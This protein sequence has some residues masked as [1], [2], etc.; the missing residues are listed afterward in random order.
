MGLPTDPT[1]NPLTPLLNLVNILAFLVLLTILVV[2]LF[3]LFAFAGFRSS[4]KRLSSSPRATA[5][6]DKI[7]STLTEQAVPPTSEGS[8]P[9]SRLATEIRA[10]LAEDR[11]QT[12]W[13]SL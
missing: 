11:R 3:L 7:Q 6:V 4:L 1:V 13:P 2:V 12:Y 9:A 5:T 10:V 8:A